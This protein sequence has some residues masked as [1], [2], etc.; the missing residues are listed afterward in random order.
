[1][2]DGY[3]SKKAAAEIAK[4]GVSKALREAR[5]TAARL[6]DQMATE[7]ERNG[8]DVSG[9]DA[10]RAFSAALVKGLQQ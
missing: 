4:N 6:A 2:M 9:P 5:L 8:D 7:M 1:M 10:L 3:I